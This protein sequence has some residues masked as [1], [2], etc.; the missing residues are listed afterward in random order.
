FQWFGLESAASPPVEEVA[1]KLV[2]DRDEEDDND[3]GENPADLNDRHRLFSFQSSTMAPRA[4]KSA[5]CSAVRPVA[6]LRSPPVR[7]E[8]VKSAP[9]RSEPQNLTPLRSLSPS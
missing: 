2:V 9:V 7:M 6:P 4:L 3:E 1:W 5:R 8:Q